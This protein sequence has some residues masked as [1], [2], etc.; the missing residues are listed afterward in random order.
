MTLLLQDTPNTAP[1]DHRSISVRA[2]DRVSSL[3]ARGG[4]RRAKS[5]SRRSFVQRAA[6]IGT[7]LAVNP[8]DFLLRPGTAYAQ[9]CGPANE[10]NQGW[11][12]FCCTINGGRN[13]CPDGSYAAGW[14]KVSS[15]AFCRGADRYVVDCNRLPSASCSCRCADGP[16]D[17]RL[18][19]CNNFRYGQCNLQ[20]PGTTEVV[21]RIIICTTPWD[22]DP[23]C[24]T[25]VRIDE[26]T[27]DHSASCL[28]GTNPSEIELV[29][30]DL[31]LVGSTLGAAQGAELA[32]PDGGSWQRYAGGVIV[33][34]VE[35]GI[36]VV[37]GAAGLLYAAED[38]P[39]G[40]LGYVTGDPIDIDGGRIIPTE[41]GAIYSLEDGTAFTLSGAMQAKYNQTGGLDGWLGLPASTILDSPG[42]RQR[43]DFS[44]GWSLVADRASGEVRVFPVDVE[45]PAT[46]GTWP[47]TAGVARWDGDTRLT[48]AI[49][50]SVESL[51]DGAP[52]AVLAASDSFPDALA[53]GVLAG[54]EGGPVLLT[55]SESLASETAAEL[56][57]L[58]VE[59]VVLVGGPS[60][61]DE[62]VDDDVRALLPQAEVQRIAGDSRF[63]TAAAVSRA[64]TGEVGSDSDTSTDTEVGSDGVDVVYLTNGR[65]FPD[66]LT[67]SPAAAG[68]GAPL[69]LTEPTQLPD[70][71][72]EELQRLRPARVVI[73]GGRSAVSG[74]VD[75]D[76][77]RSTDARIERVE[78]AS[79]Y[80]T[81]AAVVEQT[82]PDAASSV[83]LATGEEFADALAAGAAAVTTSSPLLL[84]STDLVPR[85][86]RRAI[87]RLGPDLLVVGGGEVA[88]S[89]AA[90]EQLGGIPTGSYSTRESGAEG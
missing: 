79:R 90:V 70:E 11:T 57:R 28:P 5:Q 49:R 62:R 74:A 30:L 33:R 73:V 47:A 19:C 12:A 55:G 66:A 37:T 83:I 29:Y 32:G 71:T 54:I 80:D 61:L 84:I 2:V 31:G 20:I 72:R 82:H 14:W 68:L 76:I 27:R 89:G 67:A 60:V 8:F 64:I 39:D 18:V 69:L 87:E 7:A 23:S 78:G 43:V 34:S 56:Q 17:R 9:V 59:R 81:A 25:T 46:V 13:T 16:C 51:P 63:S 53:G 4:P 52:M 22:W 88:V 40:R 65:D 1:T 58:D 15:S 75:R 6:L 3:L 48:T 45:M 35:H 50:I 86:S 24:T 10:C 44:S 42:N 38:G 21:C 26:Q 36:A 77:R 85:V 41:G